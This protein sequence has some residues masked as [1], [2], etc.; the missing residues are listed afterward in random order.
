MVVIRRFGVSS[1]ARRDR[2]EGDRGTPNVLCPGEV[3]P[4]AL[5]DA[6]LSE[7][8]LVAALAAGRA[9]LDRFQSF[10]RESSLRRRRS[11]TALG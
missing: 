8:L 7:E 6:G 4:V 10:V 9:R 3:P 5:T 1:F 2:E 11:V